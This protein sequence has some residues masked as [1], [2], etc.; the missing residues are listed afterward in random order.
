MTN[1][2][3]CINLRNAIHTLR[4]Q[5]AAQNG[6]FHGSGPLTKFFTEHDH[7]RKLDKI[8]AMIMANQSIYNINCTNRGS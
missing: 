3:D 2:V 1:T 6:G 8:D 4:V 5:S 7:L